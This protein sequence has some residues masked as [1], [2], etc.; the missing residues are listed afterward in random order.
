MVF[1]GW[2][3]VKEHDMR[4][5]PIIVAS[6]LPAVVL[7]QN[8]EVRALFNAGKATEVVEMVS[9]TGGADPADLYVAGLS[10]QKLSHN[11][12]AVSVFSQLA[13]RPDDDP[14]H[15]I[16]ESAVAIAHGNT[17]AGLASARRAVD[18]AGGLAYA[19]YQ[20]GLALGY[21][22]DYAQAASAF[23]RAAELDPGL[24]YAHYHAGLSYSRVKRIDKMAMHFERF[25]KLAPEAPERGQV[26]SIMRTVRGR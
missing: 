21:K 13:S 23:E 12:E 16:G 10:H 19:H 5:I 11:N 14:W 26:E 9:R 18:M 15:F 22:N 4:V 24:A 3:R 17:D 25:L 1:V 7:G 2:V 8:A 20:V 6:L